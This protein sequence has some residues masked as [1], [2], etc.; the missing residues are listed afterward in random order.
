MKTLSFSPVCRGLS[1]QHTF[2]GKMHNICAQA[3]VTVVRACV[4]YVPS[5]TDSKTVLKNHYNKL[6]NL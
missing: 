4:V 2:T 6:L 5:N 1:Y 3:L